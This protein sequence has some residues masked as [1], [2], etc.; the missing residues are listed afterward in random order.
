MTENMSTVELLKE[1]FLGLLSDAANDVREEAILEVTGKSVS[2]LFYLEMEY[3][4]ALS[5]MRGFKTGEIGAEDPLLICQLHQDYRSILYRA[6]LKSLPIMDACVDAIA[7][8]TEIRGALDY[9]LCHIE[10]AKLDIA[11]RYIGAKSEAELLALP[12]PE[13]PDI[14]SI[15]QV[16]RHA[17]TVG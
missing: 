8:Y 1:K 17:A 6:N 12:P 3:R 11:S 14:R 16:Y 2:G 10:A 13:W 4:E 7:E 9:V 5:L 15:Q